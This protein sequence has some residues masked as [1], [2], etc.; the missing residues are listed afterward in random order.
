MEYF[1]SN[2]LKLSLFIYFVTKSNNKDNFNRFEKKYNGSSDDATR[3]EQDSYG[4]PL[5]QQKDI[6]KIHWP[7]SWTNN[8]TDVGVMQIVNGGTETMWVRYGGTIISDPDSKN[9]LYWRQFIENASDLNG[10][11]NHKWNA[12]NTN[13][14]GGQGDGFQ[15]NPGEYQIVPFTGIAA[16]IAASLGC[17]D[18]GNDCILNNTGRS[19]STTLLEWTVPGV[20]DASAVDGFSVSM[21]IEIDDPVSSDPIIN[22]AFS[23]ALCTNPIKDNNNQY[24][25][26]KSMCACQD[27]LDDKCVDA[28]YS[29]TNV[30]YYDSHP[31][32]LPGI[33][34]G[35]CGCPCP[36]PNDADL[37]SG[38]RDN[39]VNCSAWL[40]KFFSEDKAGKNY[41]NSITK[42]TQDS[43]GNRSIYCQ[44]YDD[45]QGTK[46]L[47]NGVIK[48][49]IYNKD[50][51]WIKDRTGN[52]SCGS[53][54]PTPQI[55][56][57][58]TVNMQ[59]NK[60]TDDQKYV[61]TN[62]QTPPNNPSKWGCS[63]TQFP[64]CNG[65]QC[66]KDNTP[67]PPP[68]DIP[69]CSKVR[70]TGDQCGSNKYICTNGQIPPNNPSKWG[71]SQTQ[72]PNCNGTQCIK[73]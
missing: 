68:S 8:P 17:C 27:T 45:L 12:L 49:T 20:W 19:G 39:S 59:D 69:Y 36:D 34:G 6:A 61:C 52:T 28:D 23:Q 33:K 46:S 58:K 32:D 7:Y 16:W 9:N 44:A 22:L 14:M 73:E 51:E 56:D 4:I 40:R 3:A 48:V 43:S 54:P 57:C 67:P 5:E 2:R 70:V 18:N 72:F 50:F 26:C 64:D 15:L 62:G 63:Q 24:L 38:C 66:I 71:C 10:G 25:G 47:G 37:P 13:G 11:K 35:Y 41:C 55:P 31:G 30:P 21:R 53:V 1:F 29:K 65:T 42:M 60:C